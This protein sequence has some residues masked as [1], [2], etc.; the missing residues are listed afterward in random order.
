MFPLKKNEILNIEY[1]LLVA[2]GVT[3][4]EAV[5]PE[6][7]GLMQ[8]PSVGQG[9]HWSGHRTSQS[10]GCFQSVSCAFVPGSRQAALAESQFLHPSHKL[11][12]R[13]HLP[14]L[15]SSS[16]GMFQA[17]SPQPGPPSL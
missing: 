7:E 3:L 5:A 6:Q 10:L 13:S 2:A 14:A 17:L 9:V 4:L 11:R 12:K 15:D 16:G 8:V 1:I